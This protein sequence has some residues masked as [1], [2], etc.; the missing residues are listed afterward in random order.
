LKNKNANIKLFELATDARAGIHIVNMQNATREVHDTSEPHRDN[1]YL[2]MLATK[3]KFKLNIDFETIEFTT[4][5]LL[6]VFPEQVHHIVETKNPEGWIISFEPLLVDAELQQILENKL[7]SPISLNPKSPFFEYIISLMVLI[8]KLQSGN[9]GRFMNK[10]V[11]ALLTALLNLITNEIVSHTKSSSLKENRGFIIN[12]A[13]KQLLKKYYKT[14][15]QPAQ[16]AAALTITVA[17][18]NDIVKA[19]TGH[20]VSTHI[21][22][23]SILEAKRLLYFTDNSVKEISYETGYDEPVYFGKLFKKMTK[24]T[25]LE[26]RKQFRD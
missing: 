1:H 17:H 11:H 23:A 18:L 16:Y 4:P 24:L 6:F 22:Q 15:K 14:W 5:T 8:E 3:G 2:I 21:Q 10:S 9:S 25:P 12:D 26:F 20:S 19:L 7:V 13:F